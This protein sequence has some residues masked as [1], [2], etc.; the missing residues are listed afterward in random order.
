MVDTRTVVRMDMTANGNIIVTLQDEHN[1]LEHIVEKDV[2]KELLAEYKG[3]VYNR[4][5]QEN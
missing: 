5:R 1:R 2:P 3:E 4:L